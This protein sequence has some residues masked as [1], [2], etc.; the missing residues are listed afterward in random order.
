VSLLRPISDTLR[1]WRSRDLSIYVWF[2]PVFVIGVLAFAA[3][4]WW[5][6]LIIVP[7]LAVFVYVCKV[8][9]IVLDW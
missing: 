4:G 3:L 1:S 6:L 5:S 9:R 2:V 8:D 7:L